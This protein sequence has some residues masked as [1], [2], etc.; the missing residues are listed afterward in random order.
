MTSN[1][2]RRRNKKKNQ[3]PTV[4]NLDEV[5]KDTTE[6]KTDDANIST[7][8]ANIAINDT[9]DKELKDV[10]AMK[11]DDAIANEPNPTPRKPRR[12]KENIQLDVEESDDEEPPKPRK[13]SNS[14]T[15]LPDLLLAFNKI[16][17]VSQMNPSNLMPTVDAEIKRLH[18]IIARSALEG[19]L[20]PSSQLD[21][22]NPFTTF[23]QVI[24]SKI[25]LAEQ[26]NK[27][28]QLLSGQNP[29]LQMM[30]SLLSKTPPMA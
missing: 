8:D 26:S 25:P 14:F 30:T 13:R 27:I 7:D 16:M 17:T 9:K 2:K 10:T 29:F 5:I 11:P 19:S 20:F 18:K 1:A 24:A 28:I 15:L 3:E 23:M 22:S 21:A 4:S 12:R 6:I